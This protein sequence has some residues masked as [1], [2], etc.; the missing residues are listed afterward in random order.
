MSPARV[1]FSAALGVAVIIGALLAARTG[2]TP[3]ALT[4]SRPVE[5]P[6]SVAEPSAAAAPGCTFAP[7]QHQRWSLAARSTTRMVTPAEGPPMVFGADL[8]GQLELQVLS[9][10]QGHG[11]LV[12]RFTGLSV[13]ASE[14]NDDLTTTFL[15]DV[16]A[17]CRVTRF[18]RW[19]QADLRAARNQQ[20]LVWE[21]LF[22]TDAASL[23]GESG[24]G[25]YRAALSTR[26]EVITRVVSTYPVLWHTDAR[27][28]PVDS[29]ATITR[30]QGLWLTSVHVTQR[31]TSPEFDVE[32]S[33]ALERTDGEVTFTAA[34]RQPDAYVWEDLLPLRVAGHA[35]PQPTAI[36]LKLR[37]FATHQSLEDALAGLAARSNTTMTNLQDSWPG[38]AAW[39]QVH[40]D[41]ISDAMTQLRNGT[42]TGDSTRMSFYIALGNAHVPEARDALLEVKRDASAPPLERTRAMF[43]L[44]D[45]A[46]VGASFASELATDA[47]ALTSAP[48]RPQSYLATESLLALSMMS[49]L[50]GDAPTRE[51]ARNTVKGLLLSGDLKTVKVALAA[52]GNTGDATLLPE[53][54]SLSRHT[55]AT[56]REA[57]ASAL[58]RMPPLATDALVVQWLA[59]EQ[60]PFVKRHVYT[61]VQLQHFDAQFP[62]SEALAHKA[63]ADLPSTQSMLARKAMIRLVARSA[64]AQQPDVRAALKAQA[65]AEYV[66][67]S[68]L[69]NEFT[70]LL[71]PDEVWEVLR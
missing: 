56:V 18:A 46:D 21:A 10:Q 65:R 57:A 29:R 2:S 68:D 37:D 30:G 32:S 1:L 61:S 25:L 24:L 48:T 70:D 71:T 3:A 17:T 12:G 6:A 11:T 26:D 23:E 62:A 14:M 33:F 45:R 51:I 44:I 36:D 49:G 22:S 60:H 5:N 59:R 16:D 40:P 4:A 63:L 69:V 50:R 43:S 58:R 55:D 7:G 15:L 8:T 53:V 54:D 28:V 64:I 35:V 9:T 67:G 27:D 13:Q 41:R 38:L 42:I 66:K 34:Q 39:F 20:A 31:L 47:Q 52:V 19:Q